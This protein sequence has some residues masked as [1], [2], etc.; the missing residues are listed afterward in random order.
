[1]WFYRRSVLGFGTMELDVSLPHFGM[2]FHCGCHLSGGSPIKS[3]ICWRM[4][5]LFAMRLL[6]GGCPTTNS[7]ICFSVRGVSATARCGTNLLYS[8]VTSNPLEDRSR[9]GIVPQEPSKPVEY[10]KSSVCRPTGTIHQG[11]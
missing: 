1:M 3:A 6:Q 5:S 4:S 8:L 10:A 2:A 9:P 7:N 11:R